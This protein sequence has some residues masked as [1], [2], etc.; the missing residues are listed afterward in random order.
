MN[1]GSSVVGLKSISLSAA[2]AAARKVNNSNNNAIRRAPR[3]RPTSL[4]S[5]ETCENFPKVISPTRRRHAKI[6]TPEF[7]ARTVCRRYFLPSVLINANV[8][9]RRR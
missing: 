2:A 8:A 1:A 6:I 3:A 5:R 9:P 4:S 7:A